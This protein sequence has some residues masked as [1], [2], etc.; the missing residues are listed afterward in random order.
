MNKGHKL[1][2]LLLCAA[3]LL[4]LISP[5]A[6]A[7]GETLPENEVVLSKTPAA[8]AAQE[9]ASG[10][11]AEETPA[12][13]ESQAAGESPETTPAESPAESPKESPAESPKESPAESPKE[14]PAESPKES[15]AQ[16]PA[17]E[18]TISYDYNGGAAGAL[19]TLN[20]AQN[21]ENA[22][23]G[24]ENA[25][26]NGEN[27]APAPAAESVTGNGGQKIVLANA[28]IKP[29]RDFAGWKSTRTGKQ[30]AAGESYE[31]QGDDTLV[32]QWNMKSVLEISVQPEEG[33]ALL[34]CEKTISAISEDEQALVEQAIKNAQPTTGDALMLSAFEPE[35]LASDVSFIGADGSAQQPAAG[36]TVPMT[37]T[38]P[39]GAMEGEGFWMV[40]HLTENSEGGYIATPVQFMPADANGASVQLA[41]DGFSI[42]AVAKVH[43]TDTKG[44]AAVEGS[45]FDMFVEDSQVFYYKD[46]QYSQYKYHRYTWTIENNDDI[47]RGYATPMSDLAQD[48]QDLKRYQYPWLSVDALQEGKVTVRLN[49]YYYTAQTWGSSPTGET[50][51]GSIAFIINVTERPD[52][53]LR[54]VNDIVKDGTLKPVYKNDD[55][56]YNEDLIYTWTAKF[57]HTD[58]SGG[59]TEI[60]NEDS[61][62]DPAAFNPKD[63]SLNVAIDN[64][65][66]REE[67]VNGEEV[68]HVTTYTVTAHDKKGNLMGTASHRVEFGGNVLNGSFEYPAVPSEPSK[69]TNY[70]F[71]NGTHQLFWRTTAPGANHTLGQ[72]VELGTDRKGNPYLPAGSTAA[73]GGQY[74]ELNAEDMGT[75]YQD[76]LTAPGAELSWSFSHRSRVGSGENTMYL[77]IASS[78]DGAKIKTQ[79]QINDLIR[80]YTADGKRVIYEDRSCYTLWK[81]EGDANHWQNHF[82]SYKVPPDQYATRFFFASATG[83]T[84]GNLIDNVTFN[85]EQ[86]Y[87]IEYYLNGEKVDGLTETKTAE[88]NTTVSPQNLGNEAL[89]NAILTNS[90]INGESYGGETM[91]IL[92]RPTVDTTHRDCRNVLRLYFVTGA[93]TVRKVVTIKNWDDLTD[94]EREKLGDLGDDPYVANFELY[95][96]KPGEGQK[97]KVA[98]ASISFDQINQ[99]Q[100]IGVAQFMKLDDQNKPYP[101]KPKANAT[102][103]VKEKDVSTPTPL[104]AYGVTTTYASNADG[105]SDGSSDGSFTTDG[106]ANGSVTVTNAYALQLFELTIKTS[107]VEDIDE[108]QTYIYRVRSTEPHTK[109]VDLTVAIHGDGQATVKNLPS[110]QYKVTQVNAWSWRYTPE[111]TAERSVTLDANKTV[112]YTQ[113]RAREGDKDSNKWKWLNGQHWIDNRWMDVSSSGDVP[114]DEGGDENSI[115]D[116]KGR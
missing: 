102:Y 29:D 61:S 42:Y 22:A 45:Q 27:A 91:T 88:V 111:Q 108:N 21:G 23:Q 37:V 39:A 51:S 78:E 90:T 49:Y 79:A 96:G 67:T 33:S 5:A 43:D 93:I 76:V 95:E 101:Y 8:S 73:H 110:G 86:R 60:T 57:F 26:Q 115:K 66:I 84:T 114:G 32:A 19:L 74:A 4:T 109:L 17:G 82:G 69:V 36:E 113:K 62:I 34:A 77:I 55:G 40:Y 18:F 13:Q 35:V 105:S 83:T 100:M 58:N 89:A 53:R 30:Y 38:V 75:L 41:A 56:T 80:N 6:L 24:G 107:G 9:G 112:E 72:D 94:A 10:E 106:Q 64:G 92:P 48:P 12:P 3:V 46:D 2:S 7:E 1:L 25:A 116:G 63:G 85:Q 31:I 15:P 81:M 68:L 11:A 98:D 16:T 50:V 97:V 87:I 71:A 20:A 104:D 70:A 47:V 44:K 65:G 52:Q 54:I 103:W 59:E 14:S 28:P 99:S